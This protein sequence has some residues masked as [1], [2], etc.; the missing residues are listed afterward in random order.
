MAGNRKAASGTLGTLNGYRM[1]T[2][3]SHVCTAELNKLAEAHAG[4][5]SLNCAQ[6]RESLSRRS[7]MSRLC[8]SGGG[9]MGDLPTVTESSSGG[10]L[11]WGWAVRRLT[12]CL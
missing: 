9:A 4:M 8:R 1:G 3:F 5:L 10:S 6:R 11:C 12:N 2:R 7:A